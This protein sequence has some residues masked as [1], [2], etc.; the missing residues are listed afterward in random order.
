MTLNN[1]GEVIEI[2][3]AAVDNF[4]EALNVWSGDTG[5]DIGA[6]YKWQSMLN[7]RPRHLNLLRFVQSEL[8]WWGIDDCEFYTVYPVASRMM[9]RLLS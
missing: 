7:D 5:E 3:S 1:Q 4:I 9:D 2:A 8:R 6:P